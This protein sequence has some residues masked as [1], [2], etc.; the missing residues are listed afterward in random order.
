[1]K[2]CRWIERVGAYHDG[3]MSGEIRE[4]FEIHLSDCP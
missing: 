4:D 1:M 3:E 2:S